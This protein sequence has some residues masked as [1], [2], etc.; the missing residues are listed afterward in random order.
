MKGVKRKSGGKVY[1]AIH[2]SEVDVSRYKTAEIYPGDNW[3]TTLFP[4]LIDDRAVG[5]SS[6]SNV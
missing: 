3:R 6:L 5:F 2:R 4:H 1:K